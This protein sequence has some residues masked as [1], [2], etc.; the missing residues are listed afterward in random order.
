L[1]FLALGAGLVLPCEHFLGDDVGV[2]ADAAGEKYGRFE[3]GCA[4]LVEVVALE[5]F[6]HTSLNEVPE[7]SVWR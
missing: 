1:R 5:H 2:F 3:Y 4:D 6:A 7:V